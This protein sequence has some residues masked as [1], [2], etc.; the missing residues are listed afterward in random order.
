MRTREAFFV[1]ICEHTEFI[2]LCVLG[3]RVVWGCHAFF[4]CIC[5]HT[6]LIFICVRGVRGVWTCEAFFVCMS[7]HAELIFM[8]VCEALEGSGV[9]MRFL[10]I[11]VCAYWTH[12][13]VCVRR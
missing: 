7:V 5:E 2:F 12:F 8:C 9:F 6:E 13:Y 10:C 11:C 4:V 3:V 1:C